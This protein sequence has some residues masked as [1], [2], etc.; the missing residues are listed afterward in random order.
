MHHINRKFMQQFLNN[1]F[2]C[3]FILGIKLFSKIKPTESW[4][5]IYYHVE[6]EYYAVVCSMNEG[7]KWF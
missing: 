3:P 2:S 6:F 7:I 4:E 5:F 1:S